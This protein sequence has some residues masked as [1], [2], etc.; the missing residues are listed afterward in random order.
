MNRIQDV[1]Q[2]MS[3]EKLDAILITSRVNRLYVSGFDSSAGAMLL[4]DKEAYF[5]TDFRYIEAANS[6]VTDAHIN[7]VTTENTYEKQISAIIKEHGITNVGFENESLTYSEH[8]KWDENLEAELVP[9]QNILTQL[10]AV[11]SRADLEKM[12]KAQR[13]SEKAFLEVLPLVKPGITERQLA[14]ELI[15]RLLKNGADNVSFDPIVVSGVKTSLPHGTPGEEKIA[16]GFVTFDFGVKLEGW[17]SDTTR[18]VC[19]GTPTDEMKNVY[20][21][22]LKAQKA[23]IAQA[24][25]G[26]IGSSIDSA[27]RTVISDA[28][29]GDY[30]GHGFGHGLGLE[31]HESRFGSPIY[32]EEVPAGAVMTAEP[33]IYLPGKFGVRIEDTIFITESGNENITKLEK[34]LL[35]I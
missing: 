35:I 31:V 33:G 8:Q 25:A 12:I 11:K 32:T 26:V 23:G 3:S 5:F 6:K 2:K 13:I 14:A 17:C 20:E 21:T 22:V 19:V 29:Y 15:Y 7:V 10:R 9:A 24:C 16:E 30:F 1:R 18:T 34:S 28:G 4:T 27:A